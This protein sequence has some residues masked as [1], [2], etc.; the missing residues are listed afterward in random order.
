[1]SANGFVNGKPG[2]SNV[3]KLVTAR[4]S[5]SA[6][7]IVRG[8]AHGIVTAPDC[9]NAHDHRIDVIEIE[10][11]LATVGHGQDRANAL[12]IDLETD[13]DDT[14]AEMTADL[15]LR[16]KRSCPKRNFLVSK[17][18]LWRTYSG[19]ATVLLPRSLSW[20]STKS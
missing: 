9:E 15:A 14:E 13:T 7:E 16:S 8:I 17:R 2:S 4:D 6:R 5:V 1:M 3:P 18:K 11:G 10:T 19:T 20:K 12:G